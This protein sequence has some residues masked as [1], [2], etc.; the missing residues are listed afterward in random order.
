MKLDAKELSEEVE[1]DMSPMIDMVFLLLI[2]FIVAS[3]VV[4]DKP[5]VEV[6]TAESAAIAG[7]QEDRFM[8]SISKSEDPLN[9]YYLPFDAHNPVPWEQLVMAVQDAVNA[10]PDVRIVVRADNQVPFKE[11]EKLMKACAEAG[12]YN[13]IFSAFEEQE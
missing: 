5:P 11:T 4:S 13:M 12:A 1:I 3:Q 2:F 9:K 7:D 6:P 10:N 8:I